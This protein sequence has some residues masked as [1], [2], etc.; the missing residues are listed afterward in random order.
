M[1]FAGVGKPN[2][3]NPNIL[4]GSV[5]PGQVKSQNPSLETGFVSLGLSTT[6]TDGYLNM[7]YC[8]SSVNVGLRLI[9][10]SIRSRGALQ[11]QTNPPLD[12][13]PPAA[14]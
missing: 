9:E 8:V 13:H 14:R 3:T 1:V 4:N 10:A 2:E 7:R 5:F 12:S 11:I 6:Q